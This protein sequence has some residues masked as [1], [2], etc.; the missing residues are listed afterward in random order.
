MR[1]GVGG[2]R[3]HEERW[4]KRGGRRTWG[5][6]KSAVESAASDGGSSG[7]GEGQ[8]PWGGGG[9]GELAGTSSVGRQLPSKRD[10]E[11]GGCP[12]AS[13]SM[14]KDGRASDGNQASGAG[15]VL[16]NNTASDTASSTSCAWRSSVHSRS[17]SLSC[18]LTPMLD[19]RF[20]SERWLP[21]SNL[22]KQAHRPGQVEVSVARRQHPTP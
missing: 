17:R 22:R 8:Q 4:A 19:V 2:E 1:V 12:E 16:A 20:H 9:G 13:G 5:W 14:Q 21:N 3:V 7:G 6:R 18:T 15:G 11:T 10:G